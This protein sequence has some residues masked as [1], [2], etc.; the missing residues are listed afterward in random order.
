MF[1][2]VAFGGEVLRAAT[3][4]VGHRG[5]LVEEITRRNGISAAGFDR[6]PSLTSDQELVNSLNPRRIVQPQHQL[7]THRVTSTVIG[8]RKHGAS[9]PG[10]PEPC[11]F[12]QRICTRFCP[13][14]TGPLLPFPPR[15]RDTRYG[16]MRANFLLESG[17]STVGGRL[18]RDSPWC[19]AP[20]RRLS[21]RGEQRR[22]P[23]RHREDQCRKTAP[24]SQTGQIIAP[25]PATLD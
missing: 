4:C 2:S 18:S 3:V 15:K 19:S 5:Q 7:R 25:R 23:I 8:A 14:H 17:V 6:F 24:V 22:W 16:Q 13:Y 21:L 9:G 20:L 10:P 12:A 11:N 1:V